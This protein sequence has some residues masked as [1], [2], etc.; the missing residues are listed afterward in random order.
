LSSENV[1]KRKQEAP[2]F[3]AQRQK[4]NLLWNYGKFSH[5][6]MC[7]SKA[8]TEIVIYGSDGPNKAKTKAKNSLDSN[9]RKR[10]NGKCYVTN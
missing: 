10:D 1:S 9:T 6:P 4:Q 3:R 7:H 5:L 8:A 2:E